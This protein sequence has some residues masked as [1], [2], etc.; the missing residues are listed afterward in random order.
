M[1]ERGDIYAAC[2]HVGGHQQAHFTPAQFGQHVL[3]PAL[4]EI[5]RKFVRAV[6]EALKHSCNIVHVGLGVAEDNGG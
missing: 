5:G 6:A 3:A 2:G 1:R 4:T